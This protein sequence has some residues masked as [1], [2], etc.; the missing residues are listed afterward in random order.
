MPCCNQV[1]Q[2]CLHLIVLLSSSLH[3]LR[4]HLRVRSSVCVGGI[5]GVV[6]CEGA[7]CS[8]C[9]RASGTASI[10]AGVCIKIYLH[11]YI[12]SE[13]HAALRLCLCLRLCCEESVL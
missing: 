4:L 5:R 12:I 8:I 11:I 3:G 7:S 9:L 10:T 2:D 6:C 1:C 13:S